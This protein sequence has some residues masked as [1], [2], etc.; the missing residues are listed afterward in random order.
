MKIT[1]K[2]RNDAYHMEAMN[3]EGC[4]VDIDAAQKIGG[5]NKGFRPMQLLAAGAGSCSSID[6]IS[7]LKKQRQPLKDLEV[8]IDAE[9][10]E[11]AVPALFTTIHLHYI[12]TGDLD[13]DKVEKAINLS[14]DKYCSVVKIL[15]KT[16]KIIHSYEII[17]G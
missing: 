6:I 8:K 1:I 15:E 14:L 10:E 9:R 13:K 2:R 16:A 12:L 11:N 4:S 5:E 17:P 7:I 3:E